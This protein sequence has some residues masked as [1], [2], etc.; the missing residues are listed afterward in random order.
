MMIDPKPVLL[1]ARE[2]IAVPEHWTQFELAEDNFGF[3]VFP[4]DPD[5]YC[6]CLIG[7]IDRATAELTDFDFRKYDDD[8]SVAISDIEDLPLASTAI[9]KLHTLIPGLVSDFNDDHTHEE[10][11][12][13]LDRALAE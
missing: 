2:I 1:R 7:A 10:V 12:G 13:L 5:A 11:I 4:F 8:P 6:F 9:R 3:P